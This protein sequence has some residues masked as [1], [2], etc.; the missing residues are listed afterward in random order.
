MGSMHKVL[1]N[2]SISCW[3]G[4][5]EAISSNWKQKLPEMLLSC[6]RSLLWALHSSNFHTQGD[7]LDRLC[8]WNEHSYHL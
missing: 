4:G 2:H 1:T 6:D 3:L 7:S 5:E 8:L